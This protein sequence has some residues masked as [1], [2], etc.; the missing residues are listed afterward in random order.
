M[1]VINAFI[2]DAPGDLFIHH[3]IEG[4]DYIINVPDVSKG[5]KGVVTEAIMEIKIIIQGPKYVIDWCHGSCNE[6]ISSKDAGE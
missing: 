5:L 2:I 4:N 1:F 3:K 6:G